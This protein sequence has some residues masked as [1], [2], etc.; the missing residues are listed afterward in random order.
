MKQALASPAYYSPSGCAEPMLAKAARAPGGH[1]A[2]AQSSER[3]RGSKRETFS[4]L[5]AVAE[6]GRAA[7]V[8]CGS[9]PSHMCLAAP[10]PQLCG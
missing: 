8:F 4:R 3:R 7:S 6:T 9:K 10:R 2:P 1:R 5:S